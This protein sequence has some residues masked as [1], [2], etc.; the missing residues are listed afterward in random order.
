MRKP[1]LFLLIIFS[2]WIWSL[3]FID[4]LFYYSRHS[5]SKVT[6]S[7][8][9]LIPFCLLTYLFSKLYFRYYEL[10]KKSIILTK[11]KVNEW[12]Y[13]CL[14]F[15]P[16]LYLNF[17]RIMFPD[18]TYDIGAYHLYLQELNRYENLKNFNMV[19]GGGG[20]TY[21]FT[22]SYKM[23]GA[24][25]HLLG[26]RVGVLFNTF[27]LFISYISLYDF[28]KLISK[29]YLGKLK[30]SSALLA[31]S[32]LFII[33][34]TNT[35]FVLNS[36]V[37]DLLGIP[38]LLELLF[39]ICFKKLNEQ[40]NWSVILFFLSLVSLL[41]AY[42]LTYLPYIFVLSIC[43]IIHNYSYLI[44][45]KTLL[46]FCIIPL[47]FPS[48]YL[49]YNYT[50]TLNPIFPFYNKLFKSSLYPLINFKDERWGPHNISEMFYYNIICAV[51][52]TRNNEWNIF[53]VRLLAEYF[54]IV[55]SVV[56][57]IYN[58]FRFKNT[59]I[60][61]IIS[62][63]AIALLMNYMLLLTTGYYRYGIIIEMM[64]G[65]CIILWLLFFFQKKRYIL[66][67]A[68]L[69]LSLIQ[70]VNTFNIIYK[71]G[72]NLSWYQYKDLW[73]SNNGSL[74]KSQ[75][76]LLFNDK[77]MDVAGQIS[78]LHIDG[79]LSSECDGYSQL[80]S[81]HA[82]IYNVTSYGNR[83]DLIKDFEKNV[84]DTLSQR[85]NLYVVCRLEN[86]S[87]KIRDLNV[88]NY[89]VDSIV[90]VYPNFTSRDIPVYLL[91][92]KRYN[93]D[94]FRIATQDSFIRNAPAA[95]KDLE[96]ITGDN[97]K[98]FV[99][100]D[101]YTY[102]WPFQQDSA[103]FTLNDKLYSLKLSD[104]NKRILIFSKGDTTFTFDKLNESNYLVIIQELQ[105]K[106]YTD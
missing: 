16:I 71:H 94:S 7:L 20:G 15:L 40:N 9:A 56:Y 19:G 87:Q 81:P 21:F 50:E 14:F 48:I 90:N 23:F 31:L 54:L 76:H 73:K 83:Q 79:F 6:G 68:L 10:G 89:F 98:L 51:D 33:Y 5:Y 82:P 61:L 72:V 36:Y 18:A 80:L 17:T 47:I 43:F 62:V 27:L 29:F 88:R 8:I 102:T 63:S 95:N 59:F 66:F 53:S 45:I 84:I 12:M 75:L 2:F 41:I 74:V 93:V 24:A 57:L 101:P 91:K 65:L 55:A 13:L 92:I 77:Q 58:K 38:L 49:L 1:F 99:I 44:K 35:L 70:C 67:S 103:K 78:Q 106:T 96:Y 34:A 22:L 11:T 46:L 30:I 42:K 4:I 69:I 104:K 3:D 28:L 60:R 105:K 85:H 86:I 100:L 26:F 52:K 32:S 97:Y 64:F 25:R 39:I 37:V